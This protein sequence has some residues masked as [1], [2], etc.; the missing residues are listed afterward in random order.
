MFSD[1]IYVHGSQSSIEE[2][3]VETLKLKEIDGQYKND[4]WEIEIVEQDH[5]WDNSKEGHIGYR[6][7]IEIDSKVEKEE[8]QQ[9]IL[10]LFEKL[11]ETN[12][13]IYVCWD[14]EKDFPELSISKDIEVAPLSLRDVF[15][16]IMFFSTLLLVI[17]IVALVIMTIVQLFI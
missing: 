14:Y 13:Y 1:S 11:K 15:T 6:W 8:Y 5:W 10:A 17:G 7:T 3:V 4:F 2:A 9:S 12:K 16:M